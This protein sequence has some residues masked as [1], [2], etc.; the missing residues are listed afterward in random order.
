VERRE[1]GAPL[2]LFEPAAIARRPEIDERS[3]RHDAR[4]IDATL[5]V[6]IEPA[7]IF[8]CVAITSRPIAIPLA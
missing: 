8:F 3:D 1:T 6:L 7:E 2:P 5:A 4:W